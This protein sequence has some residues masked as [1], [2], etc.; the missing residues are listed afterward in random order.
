MIERNSKVSSLKVSRKKTSASPCYPPLSRFESHNWVVLLQ[1]E[2]HIMF[3]VCSST[4]LCFIVLL[5]WFVIQTLYWLVI[6]VLLLIFVGCFQFSL[7]PNLPLYFVLLWSEKFVCAL[8]WVAFRFH[9][10]V[11][12]VQNELLFWWREYPWKTTPKAIWWWWQW[13]KHRREKDLFQREIARNAKDSPKMFV[14]GSVVE[15]LFKID[16]V[17]GDRLRMNS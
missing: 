4:T 11:C 8:L 12:S 9:D 5:L 2:F 3:C 6:Y 17:E 13:Q 14:C 7:V 10:W 16:L 15:N 1:F